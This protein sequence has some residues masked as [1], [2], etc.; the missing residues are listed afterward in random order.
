MTETG[1]DCSLLVDLTKQTDFNRLDRLLV[2]T[3]AYLSGAEQ[4]HFLN[5]QDSVPPSDL[6]EVILIRRGRDQEARLLIVG[7]KRP[8]AK[9][10]INELLEVYRNQYHHL[11]RGSC[12]L[13]TGLQNRRVFDEKME[14]LFAPKRS[15]RKNAMKRAFAIIDIDHFKQVNDTFGHLYGDEIL[16]LVSGIMKDS[17]RPDDWIFRF[18]GEEFIVVLN[19]V[20][21]K[22]ALGSLERFRERVANRI[23]PQV[24][25]LTV[26]VGVTRVDYDAGMTTVLTQADRALYFAKN[27]GRN[28]VA[29]YN[30]LIESGMIPPSDDIGGDL[31][32]L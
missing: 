18:G 6:G 26:S 15:G 30:Q 8:L 32:M 22:A 1:C 2:E 7:R 25:R 3:V 11:A 29:E 12:D 27:S 9:K 31:E 10:K 23:F 21:L 14:R 24:G 16:I 17:F 28:R 20:G 4:V 5:G 13:L 19:N